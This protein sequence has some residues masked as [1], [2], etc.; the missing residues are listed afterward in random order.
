MIQTQS[1]CLYYTNDILLFF[2]CGRMIY[3]LLLDLSLYLKMIL[4]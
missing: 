3:F 4:D 1:E 2:L